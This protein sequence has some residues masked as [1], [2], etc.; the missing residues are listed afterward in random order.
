MAAIAFPAADGAGTD[1]FDIP[2][3]NVKPPVLYAEAYELHCQAASAAARGEDLEE[4][5]NL[6]KAAFDKFKQA[7]HEDDSSEFVPSLISLSRNLR[8]IAHRADEKSKG[9]NDKCLLERAEEAIKHGLRE[10]IADRTSS[11]EKSK[12]WGCVEMVNQLF[13]IYFRLQKLSLCNTLIQ[14]VERAWKKKSMNHAKLPISHLVT[15]RYYQG[16]LALF[17]LQV[18][19]AQESLRFALERCAAS[20]LQNKRLILHAFIPAQLLCG[21][22]PSDHL[23][24]KYRL[25]E[26]RDLVLAVRDG[27]IQRFETSINQHQVF[28]IQ[29]GIFM[30]LPK[31]RILLYRNLFYRIY[32]LIGKE[33]IQLQ[34]CTRALQAISGSAAYD[35]NRVQ[36][37]LSMLIDKKIIR[38]YM[39]QKAGY[40]VV[41]KTNPFPPVGKL[42]GLL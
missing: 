18:R 9:R 15:F 36:G 4:A 39:S 33:K 3:N 29:K 31:I 25:D 10:T 1:P 28:F 23:M 12:I 22:F 24:S 27:N 21:M 17:N 38:G 42:R 40:L 14:Q 8:K 32:K 13:W 30:L 41:A 6:E 26:F 34:Q 2:P 5:F 35:M 16:R 19:E 20:S 7:F 11:P 37:I